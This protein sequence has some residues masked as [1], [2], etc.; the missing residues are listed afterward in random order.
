MLTALRSD[1]EKSTMNRFGFHNGFHDAI[2]RNASTMSF[3]SSELVTNAAI[4]M[5]R[6]LV[7]TH[8][9]NKGKE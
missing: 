5:Y 7:F 8:R 6:T 1:A 4:T 9:K 3:V 2:S